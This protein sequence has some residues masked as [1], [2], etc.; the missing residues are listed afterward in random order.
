MAFLYGWQSLLVMDPAVTAAL[1]TGAWQYLL[2][3]WPA[4]TGSERAIAVA[5]IWGLAVVNMAGLKLSARVLGAMTAFKLLAL[6]AIV[7]IV[8]K[9]CMLAAEPAGIVENS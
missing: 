4:S 5:A 8:V 6:A 3:L 1:A 7:I 2:V 9:K